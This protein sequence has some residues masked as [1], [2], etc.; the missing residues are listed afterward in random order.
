MDRLFEC[1]HI[2]IVISM[3]L[4]YYC[5][6]LK[7]MWETN[8]FLVY[9]CKV[10]FLLSTLRDNASDVLFRGS[11]VLNYC[12]LLSQMRL[13]S[14]KS[15]SSIKQHGIPLRHATLRCN[16]TPSYDVDNHERG[17][18]FA[19]A[20][21]QMVTRDV[22]GVRGSDKCISFR[23][24]AEKRRDRTPSRRKP[25]LPATPTDRFFS[26]AHATRTPLRPPVPF[27]RWEWCRGTLGRDDLAG[28]R[29]CPPRGPPKTEPPRFGRH[30]P[31]T[32]IQRSKKTFDCLHRRVVNNV[33]PSPQADFPPCL[34]AH[35]STTFAIE[36]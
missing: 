5:R 18:I 33:L 22:P 7:G 11:N 31:A 34:P 26:C 16:W 4:E 10:I 25:A 29:Q 23:V 12:T 28:P 3:Q 13:V 6:Y 27:L 35:R 19:G 17:M 9:K 2:I 14:K 1:T 30:G 36:P 32:T 15:I 21:R 20:R 8:F 24:C